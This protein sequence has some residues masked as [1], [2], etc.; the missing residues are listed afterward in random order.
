MPQSTELPVH[1]TVHLPFVER[2]F[3]VPVQATLAKFPT[4]DLRELLH[5]IEDVTDTNL[6]HRI[7]Q[8]T[9]HPEL[10]DAYAEYTDRH[11][12]I[13]RRLYDHRGYGL[14]GDEPPTMA[15][16][17]PELLAWI[18]DRNEP[19][20][21]HVLFDIHGSEVRLVQKGTSWTWTPKKG[22][23]TVFGP[24]RSKR[25]ALADIVDALGLKKAF[26]E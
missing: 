22:K 9:Q 1:A 23:R 13:S 11:A 19:M 15:L 12:A 20:L 24:F 21:N 17:R 16:K 8:Q 3:T 2:T 7:L 25:K 26:L 10:A 5:D 6:V 18:S 4:S 14:E